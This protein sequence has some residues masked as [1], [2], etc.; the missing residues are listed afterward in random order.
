MS[1]ANTS[2]T[3]RARAIDWVDNHVPQV[4]VWLCFIIAGVIYAVAFP[5]IWAFTPMA[6]WRRDSGS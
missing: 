5:F 4:F 6:K 1:E 2:G 3:R